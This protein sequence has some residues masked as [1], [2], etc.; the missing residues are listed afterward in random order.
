MYQDYSILLIPSFIPRMI[1]RPIFGGDYIRG[2][3]DS[4]YYPF[5]FNYG[6]IIH[7]NPFLDE[8]TGGNI[9]GW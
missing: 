5:P 1:P 4:T 6:Y 2:Y 3:F 7:E 9:N 8:T